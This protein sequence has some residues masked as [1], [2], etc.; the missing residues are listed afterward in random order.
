MGSYGANTPA[1]AQAY[2][3]TVGASIT[4]G[5]SG[6]SASAVATLIGGV[7]QKGRL[8]KLTLTVAGG[9]ITG[10]AIVDPGSGLAEMPTVIVEDAT[11]TGA[12]IAL[13]LGLD[14]V[15]ITREGGGYSSPPTVVLTPLFQALF[16]DSGDQTQPF[17]QLMTTALEQKTIGPVRAA[18]P[19]IA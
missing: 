10:V 16:P 14:S 1:A 7:K 12:I 6:Y 3:K 9:V 2:L 8:P 19:I 18:D 13:S 15:E 5:G 11:G 17:R 4:A